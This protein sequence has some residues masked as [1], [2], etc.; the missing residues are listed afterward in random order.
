M[1]KKVLS[2]KQFCKVAPV[3]SNE[4]IELSQEQQ[5]ELRDLYEGTLGNYK[6]GSL[7]QGKVIALTA[8]G[9]LVDIG[10]KSDGLI[11]LYEFSEE[12]LKKITV[13]SPIEV[14]I[15]D[16][17]S[18]EG[19]V[20]L[21]YEKAKAARAWSTI[22]K[23]FEEN[24]P[25]EGIVT[26]KVKGGLNVDISGV[27]AFLPGSQ[28]DVQR[29][30]DFD[31][32]LKQPIVAYVIKVNPKR[33][34]VIISRRKY[35]SEQRA[36]A[37]KKVM[38][39]IN[40]GD[41]IQGVVKNITNYG[42]FVDIGGVDGLLHITDMAWTRIAHPSEV[43]KIGDTIAV[44]VLTLDPVNEKISLGIK[45]LAGNPWEQLSR[46][47][48]IGSIVKGT[49]S[50][51]ADYGLFVT[52][53]K[54]VEGLIHISEISW[55]E[56]IA[57]LHKYYHIG[58]VIEAR[59]VSLDAENRR[60]S[61]SVKQLGKN[62]WDV[63]AETLKIG[64]VISGPV[65][66]VVDFGIFV[67]V[68]P[69]IDGL[70]H[71]ADFSWTEHVKH[72]TDLYKKGD[73]VEAVITDINTQ[74]KK[75]SLSVKQLQQNPW[76]TIEERYPVGAILQGEITKITDFGAFVRLPDGIE[77]LVHIS[78]LVNDQGENIQAQLSVGQQ[79]KLRVLKVSREEQKLGLSMRLEGP[80]RDARRSSDRSSESREHRGD[81]NDRG[82]R[83]GD[84]GEHKK[85]FSGDR[86]QNEPSSSNAFGEKLK[87]QLQL[88]LERHATRAGKNQHNS[89]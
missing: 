47:I 24:K 42:A 28:V 71:V 10:F 34:N 31:T 5:Q 9:V 84:R 13:G 17:E 64:Q 32:Y 3:A 49:I 59:V 72:P 11:P 70:V 45:Q 1:S 79:V 58:D 40:V 62:P 30:A 88:E 55:T 15:D 75:I 19:T 46:D 23:L 43:L 35:L 18:A 14:I 39:T 4:A 51:I 20:V 52:V 81:R 25:V 74:K 67:Q 87:S 36:D 80:T 12:D 73:I 38:D 85:R 78:E 16:L 41:V 26:H 68:A 61:L 83:G 2:A 8:D 76:D 63:V 37:R 77:G 22:M 48:S 86:R 57:D 60:M 89:D 50:S 27:P 66:N 53:A 44:K 65:S 82:D 6:Q 21:S 54:G 56:R 69:G 7:A 29:V 33:G